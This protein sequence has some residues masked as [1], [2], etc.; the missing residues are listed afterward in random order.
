MKS[1][2]SDK[3]T[4]AWFTL[5]ECVERGERERA[6]GVYRLLSHSL[7]DNAL[8]AQLEG[9]LLFAFNIPDQ[10]IERYERAAYT[11][12]QTGRFL[13]AAS[14][15]EHIRTLA[16]QNQNN[17]HRLFELYCT[18][19]FEVRA[20]ELLTHLVTFY[21]KGT[22]YDA[23]CS[24][25]SQIALLN[26]YAAQAYCYEQVVFIFASVLLDTPTHVRILYAQSAISAYFK[27]GDITN[28]QKLLGYLRATDEEIYKATTLSLSEYIHV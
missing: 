23:A 11:Y 3:Y 13:E 28:M 5:A 7:D 16:P 19:Q 1:V 26:S 21:I 6:F 25:V 8:A 12:K 14:V 9:D 24:L 18:L 20:A 22:Q 10:A 2:T 4:I 27:Q 17:T 15:C